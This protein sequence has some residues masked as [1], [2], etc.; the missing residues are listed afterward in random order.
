MRHVAGVG[1]GPCFS[2]GRLALCYYRC[3][4]I[5]GFYTALNVLASSEHTRRASPRFIHQVALP[6]WILAHN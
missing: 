4:L 5:S 1:V 2:Q 3:N 6:D